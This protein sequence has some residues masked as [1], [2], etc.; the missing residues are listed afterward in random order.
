MP[1]VIDDF[2]LEVLRFVFVHGSLNFLLPLLDNQLK[3]AMSV[4]YFTMLNWLNPKLPLQ[5][6][7][8]LVFARL[9][10]D[11]IDGCFAAAL[12][13]EGQPVKTIVMVVLY[14]LI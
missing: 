5:L 13:L 7:F 10:R 4:V 6:A 14:S 12:P 8:S 9:I 1:V 2:N 3:I 11:P